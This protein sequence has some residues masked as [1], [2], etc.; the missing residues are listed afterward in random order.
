[1]AK[2]GFAVFKV[3]FIKKLDFSN[4]IP[5]SPNSLWDISWRDLQSQSNRIWRVGTENQKSF[6]LTFFQNGPFFFFFF[7]SSCV[8][9]WHPC[10]KTHVLFF[11]FK[12]QVV[13]M[14]CRKGKVKSCGHSLQMRK[15]ETFYSGSLF[16]WGMLFVC[17]CVFHIT[18][19]G[20][21][22]ILKA[23]R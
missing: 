8:F 19:L 21:P 3:Q 22:G 2:H 16:V 7:L 17:I 9:N 4:L 20:P 6:L 1:M 11:F 15:I 18:D 12:D 13:L 10:S 14:W 23:S 5:N